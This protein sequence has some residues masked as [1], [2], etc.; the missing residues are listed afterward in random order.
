M[1]ISAVLDFMAQTR[2]N[3]HVYGYS[4]YYHVIN[5]L[6]S[7]QPCERH[8]CHQYHKIQGTGDKNLSKAQTMENANPQKRVRLDVREVEISCRH[9]TSTTMPCCLA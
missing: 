5:G 3:A 4:E 2:V 1:V 8:A 9:A 6:Q 7:D